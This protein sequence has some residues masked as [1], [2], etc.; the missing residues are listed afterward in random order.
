[1]ELNAPT[2]RKCPTLKYIDKSEHKSRNNLQ[3]TPGF[4]RDKYS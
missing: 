2:H 4:F 1:M 3:N